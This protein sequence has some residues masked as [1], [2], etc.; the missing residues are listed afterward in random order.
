MHSLVVSN[1]QDKM[2]VDTSDMIEAFHTI[3]HLVDRLIIVKFRYL[4]DKQAVWEKRFKL[5]GT[6]ILVREDLP[7][8]IENQ[9]MALKLLSMQP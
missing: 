6:N 5:K 4:S 7:V 9:Q 2:S 8:E 3:G 1:M